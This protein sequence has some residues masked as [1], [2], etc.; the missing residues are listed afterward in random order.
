MLRYWAVAIPESAPFETHPFRKANPK[1][2][3]CFGLVILAQALNPLEGFESGVTTKSSN[4]L[5]VRSTQD[6]PA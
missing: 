4:N 2:G 5:K 3:V 1:F 6:K